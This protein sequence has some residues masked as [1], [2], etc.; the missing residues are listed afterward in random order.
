MVCAGA[1][2]TLHSTEHQTQSSVMPHST[3]EQPRYFMERVPRC[4]HHSHSSCAQCTGGLTQKTHHA[5]TTT[6]AMIEAHAQIALQTQVRVRV[7]HAQIVMFRGQHCT[8]TVTSLLCK[9]GIDGLHGWGSELRVRVG[10][11]WPRGPQLRV[12]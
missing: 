8:F 9:C 11:A 10:E 2:L 7:V 3:C 5:S 4:M 1:C 6:D 12:P